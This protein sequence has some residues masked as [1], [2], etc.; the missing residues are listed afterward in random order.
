MKRVKQF[1]GF[2]SALCGALFFVRTAAADHFFAGKTITVSTYDLP[3]E[4]Y[5]VYV[6]LLIRHYGQHIPGHPSFLATNQPGAGGLL[7]IN[8]AAVLAPQDGTFLTLASQGLLIFEATGQPGLQKSLGAFHWLGS[9]S[10]SNNVTVAWAAS[11]IKTL[12]DAIDH[13]VITGAT[14]AG[15]ATVVGPLLYNAVLGTKFKIIHGYQGSGAIDIAMQRG[16]I[17]ARGNNLWA[18]LKVELPELCSVSRFF[19]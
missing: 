7:A 2:S 4:G 5:S 19:R 17:Q 14:G 10:Q 3:G 9:F 6:Q 12:Q 18:S 15:S 8:H 11:G 13:E 16:E 1:I